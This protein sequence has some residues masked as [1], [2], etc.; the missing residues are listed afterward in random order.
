MNI[1]YIRWIIM[2]P[3]NSVKYWKLFLTSD[4][5]LS[6]SN[7]LRC[8]HWWKKDSKGNMVDNHYRYGLRTLPL[9][10]LTLPLNTPK[11]ITFCYH[12]LIWRLL[13]F[14]YFVPLYSSY[15]S[16]RYI[17]ESLAI[18]HIFSAI[19]NYIILPYSQR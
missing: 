17:H 14:K 1:K 10:S 5:F 12:F 3:G 9:R 7:N 8:G 4:I 15:L 2:H 11:I 6:I 19:K 16:H 18:F 13:F